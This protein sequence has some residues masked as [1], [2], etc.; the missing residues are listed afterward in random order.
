MEIV[1]LFPV[2]FAFGVLLGCLTTER[3]YLRNF[4]QELQEVYRRHDDELK[5]LQQHHL[6]REKLMLKLWPAEK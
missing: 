3:V 4:K 2:V 6:E 1:L 5:Q